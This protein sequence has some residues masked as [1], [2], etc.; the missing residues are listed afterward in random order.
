[1]A[2]RSFIGKRN[3]DGSITG[4][5][6]HWDGYPDHNGKILKEHYTSAAKVDA[7]LELGALSSLGP[8]LG[9]KC[10]EHSFDKPMQGWTVAYKRDRGENRPMMQRTYLDT[11]H[12]K[13]M[14]SSS[15]GAE[16]AY[17]YGRTGKWSVHKL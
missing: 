5:Y 1:M 15:M 6:C 3:A 16:Y 12:M 11:K 17:V 13:S 8:E 2:T 14:V 4:V 10:K 9:T 7:L